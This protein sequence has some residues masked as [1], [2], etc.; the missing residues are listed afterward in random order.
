V[1]LSV[2]ELEQLVAELVATPKLWEG[3]VCHDSSTRIY[4][5]IWDEENVNAWLIC[6]SDDQDTGY[7]DH[8]DSAAAI[9]VIHGHVREDRLRLA[10]SPR[11]QV[12]GPGGCLSLP[13]SAIHLV[14][15]AGTGP[16]DHDPRVLTTAAT[17]GRLHRH[18]RR[19]A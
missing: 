10:S 16:R 2:S 13:A 12:I 15:H 6:W 8:N 18:D 14:L 3:F 17:N 9:Q 4:E 11:T 19:N 1:S 7:H 5:Q